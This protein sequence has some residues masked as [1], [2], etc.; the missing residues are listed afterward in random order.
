LPAYATG[1][2]QQGGHADLWDNIVIAAADVKNSGSVRGA[3]V[4]QLYVGIPN[5]PVRQL[6][7]FSKIHIQPGE[8]ESVNFPLTREI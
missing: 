6:R 4:A 5:G 7:G 1:A 2:I 8:T 3:E